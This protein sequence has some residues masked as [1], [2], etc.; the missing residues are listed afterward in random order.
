MNTNLTLVIACGNP[1]RGDAAI[2]PT[3]A[4]IVES[5][6]IPGVKI[7]S[8]HQL[9]PELIDE[10]KRGNRV[11][12][13]DAAIDLEGES[14]Q[15]HIVEPKTSRRFFGHHESPANLLSL[16]RELEG[17]TPESW[18]VSITAVSIEHG[19]EMT[20]V[21]RENLEGALEWIR[22]YLLGQTALGTIRELHD[23][24]G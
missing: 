19:E 10:M 7:L 6:R 8:V 17:R 3:A 4:N 22:C 16:M 5:W 14:F 12:F 11:L 1:L 21:A 24:G 13:I 20:E 9:V 2:G 23:K 15:C 18:L